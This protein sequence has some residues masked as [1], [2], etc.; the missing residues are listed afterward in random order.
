MVESV[1]AALGAAGYSWA[2]QGKDR[3]GDGNVTRQ[4]FKLPVMLGH[5][6]LVPADLRAGGS[7]D[8]AFDAYDHNR[9]GKIDPRELTSTATPKRHAADRF[10]SNWS[11]GMTTTQVLAFFDVVNRDNA[12]LAA[13]WGMEI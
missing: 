13:Q 8:D 9:D 1:S 4:E 10:A 11:A 5:G 12:I 7:L 6:G 3:D 2:P